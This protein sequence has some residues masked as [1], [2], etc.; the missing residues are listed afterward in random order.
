MKPLSDE[1]M[2]IVLDNLEEKFKQKLQFAASNG[3]NLKM[4][5]HWSNPST[6]L[7]ILNPCK[8]CANSP[9][10]DQEPPKRQ[11]W[12]K[13]MNKTKRSESLETI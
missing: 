10:S 12:L 5:G 7:Y 6:P 2:C 9:K 3:L 11:C 1:D 8:S 13:M 4:G